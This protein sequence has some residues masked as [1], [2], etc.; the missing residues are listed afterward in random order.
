[1]IEKQ[2]FESWVHL[3]TFLI[4]HDFQRIT[5]LASLEWLIGIPGSVGG[6]VQM[7]AGAYGYEFADHIKSVN[8]LR[9]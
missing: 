4:L 8:F 5:Q 3:R 2:Y 1:M 9:F 7:N 6:A